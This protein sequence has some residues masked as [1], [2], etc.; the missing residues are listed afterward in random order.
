MESID[1]LALIE[2][3]VDTWNQWRIDHPECRPNLSRAY[4]YGHDLTGF[5]LHGVNLSRAC[6][7]GA[8]LQGANLSGA[9]L[10]SAYASSADLREAVLREADLRGGNF[11]EA[12]F[13]EANLASSDVAGANFGGACFTGVCIA[14]W[15]TDRATVLGGVQGDY[16]RLDETAMG[17]WPRDGAFRDGEL[18]KFL[19][20]RQVKLHASTAETSHSAFLSSDFLSS[21]SQ[22]AS[23]L[24][25]QA[26]TAAST[27]QGMIRQTLVQGWIRSRPFFHQCLSVFAQT[28]RYLQRSVRH[29][30]IT[31]RRWLRDTF[32]PACK[33]FQRSSRRAVRYRQLK[34][35]RKSQQLKTS[36]NT[37]R[38]NLKPGWTSF[39]NGDRPFQV[40]LIKQQQRLR[41]W[42]VRASRVL[43]SL[44]LRIRK[45]IYA[46]TL[47]A[48]QQSQQFKA[49]CD[50]YWTTTIQPG[51]TEFM[52]GDRPFQIA[53]VNRQQR[54]RL[55]SVRASRVLRVF[56][57]RSRKQG[58]AAAV[59]A[60]RRSR[61]FHWR[62][63]RQIQHFTIWA[64]RRLRVVHWRSKRYSQKLVT[65]ATVG[66]KNV[67][68]SV[69]QR[70][71]FPVL[72]GSV[73][74]V[75]L[76]ALNVFSRLDSP[77]TPAS[78]NALTGAAAVE[79]SSAPSSIDQPITSLQSVGSQRTEV[80]TAAQTE[81]GQGISPQNI[82]A[83]TTD[84]QNLNSVSVA[85]PPI[86][87]KPLDESLRYQYEDGSV[88]YGK[89]ERGQPADGAG[90]MVYAT[91]NRYDGEYKQGRR[92]G[93]GTFSYTNGRRYIGQ[94]AKDKF[95]GQGTW[96]LEN[97]ERYIG[98][99]ENNQ[100]SGQGTFVF[101][102]GE[103]KSGIWQEG[104]LVGAE[105]S[106]ER[107]S[108]RVPTSSD[109]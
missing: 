49:D 101:L 23:Q 54:L 44:T 10:A 19:R 59:L 79:T 83:Q 87:L 46:L 53:L 50:T 90:T 84:L 92:E 20:H 72:L 9:C 52:G 26:G 97:G 21:I 55:Q 70:H 103:V 30:W 34:T 3:G 107:G 80:Q 43:K 45:N 105:L 1:F 31:F 5:D 69:Y 48:L 18:A 40:E 8:H 41:V 74:T 12:D 65:V 91:G 93:C 60:F 42:S 100:C 32:L 13:S 106:C 98:S 71:P 27:L 63:R 86:A 22:T 89:V 4:L 96:I 82:H 108:L 15:Q 73:S 104:E 16:I 102:N 17:R 35:L 25:A 62:S 7:I 95:N 33:R 58:H 14:S 47:L 94:F 39:I 66:N 68:V 64:T 28:Y 29:L 24:L 109:N 85:C 36:F 76:L 75:L 2:Q 56:G 77:L 11:S 6:L 38:A 78:S 61:V 37:H 99:F 88:Y 57:L 81:A 51:W 67:L